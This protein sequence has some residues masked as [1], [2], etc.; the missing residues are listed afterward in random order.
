MQM[1]HS[2][3]RHQQ[4]GRQGGGRN[5]QSEQGFRR[6][7][8]DD[9][10][11]RYSSSEGDDFESRNRS[12]GSQS[13]R[14]ADER[15]AGGQGAFA[16]SQGHGQQG[17]GGSHG[18][19]PQD[20]YGSQGQQRGFQSQG[21]GS[22]GYGG[23]GGG[24]GAQPS[25]F[26]SQGYGQGQQAYGQYGQQS[27]EPSGSSAQPFRQN[28]Q[29]GYGAQQGFA[30][31]REYGSS[32]LGASGGY[33]GSQGTYAGQQN[34]Y[35]SQ[36]RGSQLGGREYLGTQSGYPGSG[37]QGSSGGLQQGYGGG[38]LGGQSGNLGSNEFGNYGASSGSSYGNYGS[39]GGMGQNLSGQGHRGKGPKGYTRSDDRIKED[40]CERLSD[41][42]L[43]DASDVSIEAKQ[44]IVTLTGSVD[45]RQLKHRIED[46]IE[47]CSGVKDVEN[48]LTVKSGTQSASRS[49]SSSA[50]GSSTTG[51]SG[52]T[53]SASA[54]GTAGSS[55]TS[56][57]SG[58]LS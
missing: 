41:D 37:Y 32:G 39:S 13:G 38:S 30:A 9:E 47:C 55:G 4:K 48:R 2:N 11:T 27:Y 28:P 34:D 53:T 1:N 23:Y 44:G 57:G 51:S 24:Y 52:S 46:M 17:Y 5:R 49:S 29:Q 54:G 3:D 56:S 18:Y 14:M 6:Q 12:Y 26:Q 50:S 22:Q 20:E 35:L 7:D 40:I 16:Q 36:G 19:G 33:G 58:K 43:I 8:N 42:P 10:A 15:Y 31:Q 25:Q 45:S 21:S